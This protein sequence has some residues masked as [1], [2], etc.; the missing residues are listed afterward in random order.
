MN[1]ISV[2]PERQFL[3]LFNKLTSTGQL[4]AAF[5]AMQKV[6][7]Y[8]ARETINRPGSDPTNVHT[9]QYVEVD[10]HLFSIHVRVVLLPDDGSVQI[11]EA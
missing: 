7:Q 10:D 6:L 8:H 3:N 4:R 1:G 11:E 9:S 5:N 2:A